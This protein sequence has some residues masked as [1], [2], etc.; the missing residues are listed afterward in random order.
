MSKFIKNTSGGSKT[1]V[2]QEVANN[3]YYEIQSTEIS[4]WQNNSILITDIGNS[5]AVVAKDDSGNTDI[6]DVSD[7]LNYLKDTDTP[8]DMDGVPLS[9]SKI[10]RTGWHFQMHSL[11]FITSK[12]ASIFNEDVDGTDLGFTTI[13]YYNGSDTELVAGTQAELDS[14]CVKTVVDFEMDQD[15]EVIGGILEQPTAPTTDV[16]IWVLAIPDLTVA[17]GGSVPFTNGGINLRYISN[18]LDI[19]GRTPKLLP[20]DATYHTNKFRITLKH[21]AGTQC[22]INLIFKLFRENI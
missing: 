8:V 15:I 19:D 10:T 17:Q 7:G 22:P 16:R 4:S 11:E 18:N 6:A 20:Y 14:N 12:L 2:G 1:W 5:D 13:K 9:R 21:T 3:G